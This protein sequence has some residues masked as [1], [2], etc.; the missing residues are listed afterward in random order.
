MTQMIGV[1]RV[2]ERSEMHDTLAVVHVP[3]GHSES[4]D[5]KL[6]HTRPPVFSVVFQELSGTPT[7]GIFSKVLP[8]Q[9]GGVLR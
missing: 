1:A 3:G 9:M 5:E 8:V 4:P 7:T 2:E 6:G